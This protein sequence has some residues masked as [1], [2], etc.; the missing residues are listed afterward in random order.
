MI[1]IRR[2]RE[3]VG[4]LQAGVEKSREENRCNKDTQSEQVKYFQK[5]EI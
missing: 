1:S 4:V 3:Y 5:V 2:I